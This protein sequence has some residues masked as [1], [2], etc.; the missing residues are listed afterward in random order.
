MIRGEAI[1]DII[2]AKE[3]NYFLLMF[4]GLWLLLVYIYI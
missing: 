3:D 1:V 4:L 2:E